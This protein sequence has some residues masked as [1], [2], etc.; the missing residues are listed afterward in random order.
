[1]E[2]ITTTNLRTKTSQLVN[3]LKK[4]GK[5]SLIHRSKIIGVIKPVE[6]PKIFDAE[7]FNKIIKKLNLPPTTYAQREKIYRSHLMKKY[8]K[9]IS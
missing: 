4:G 1:M 6:E 9:G 8:G 7:K 5:V 2:Y 3:E